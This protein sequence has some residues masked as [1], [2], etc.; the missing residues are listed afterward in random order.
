MVLK[1]LKLGQSL[2]YR[3]DRVQLPIHFEQSVPSFLGIACAF[4]IE[5]FPD[6]LAFPAT[7]GAVGARRSDWIL[8][9]GFLSPAQAPKNFTHVLRKFDPTT[10]QKIDKNE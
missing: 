7:R 3:L 5:V 9:L 10:P 6:S 4:S 8:L 2:Y 1:V